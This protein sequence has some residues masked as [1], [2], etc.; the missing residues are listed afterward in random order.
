MH[1]LYGPTSEGGGLS[2]TCGLG[3]GIARISRILRLECCNTRAR[4]RTPRQSR[5][6]RRTRAYWSTLTI[7]LLLAAGHSGSA[8]SRHLGGPKFDED[9]RPAGGPGLDEDYPAP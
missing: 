9:I 1:G 4:A 7:F 5:C 3:S 6:A 2:H 8:F